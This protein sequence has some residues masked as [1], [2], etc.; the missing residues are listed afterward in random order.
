MS[1]DKQNYD[2]HEISSHLRR[3]RH[4]NL[5]LDDDCWPG[6]LLPMSLSVDA[7]ETAGI[8]HAAIS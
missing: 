4:R 3:F 2:T 8:K 7:N 1:R 5:C 6:A